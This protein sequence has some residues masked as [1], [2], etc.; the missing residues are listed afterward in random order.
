MSN[1]TKLMHI[2]RMKLIMT[3]AK[4]VSGKVMTCLGFKDLWNIYV[5]V[6]I[7]RICHS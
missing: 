7:G 1:L 5:S 4:K 6:G 2:I 3:F